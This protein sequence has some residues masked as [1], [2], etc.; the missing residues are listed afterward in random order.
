MLR[1]ARQLSRVARASS[2]RLQLHQ[3]S[4]H[5]LAVSVA[6]PQAP[7]SFRTQSYVNVAPRTYSTSA[8]ANECDDTELPDV[9]WPSDLAKRVHRRMRNF[10]RN[11]QAKELVVEAGMNPA[12]WAMAASSFRKSFLSTPAKYFENQAELLAF[13]RDLDDIKR[14]NSFIFYPYF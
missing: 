2:T 13:G 3:P 12:E 7:T 8:I 6:S 4:L 10:P 9:K 14:H 11:Y 5:L 1:A